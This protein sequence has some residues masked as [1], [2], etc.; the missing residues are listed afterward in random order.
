MGTPPAWYARLVAPA[1]LLPGWGLAAVWPGSSPFLLLPLL[2]L[3]L[4]ARPESI[5]VDVI[6]HELIR[7]LTGR[8]TR[9][10]TMM[11]AW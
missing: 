9:K 10:K 11:R 3:L 6:A 5:M 2:P 4:A 8:L 1:A 7:M